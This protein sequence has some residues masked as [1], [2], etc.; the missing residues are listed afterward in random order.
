MARRHVGALVS[1][2]LLLHAPCMADIVTFTGA[3]SDD[4]HTSSNWDKGIPTTTDRVIIPANLHAVIRLDDVTV[5]TVE[6][7]AEASLTV[8]PGLTLELRNGIKNIGG[9]GG[10]SRSCR[11]GDNSRIDGALVLGVS[12][13]EG[14]T[15]RIAS[16]NHLFAGDGMIIG[17]GQF[18]NAVIL[19]DSG[20]TL[21]NE[22]AEVDNG[23]RGAMTITGDGHLHNKGRVDAV[24]TLEIET[25]ISDAEGAIWTVGCKSFMVFHVGSVALEGD[26]SDR[27]AG[28][29]RPGPGMFTFH[30]PVSTCGEYRRACGGITITGQ[31]TYFEY[32]D[33]VDLSNAACSNPGSGGPGG[34]EDP[35]IVTSSV[36]SASCGEP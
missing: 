34:C 27:P 31:G 23:I 26:F 3:T 11:A 6:I 19:I 1:A 15:L 20:R 16:C 18:E 7:E 21:T 32:A 2:S 30:E 25:T 14:A 22:L 28:Q 12:E 13:T 17:M 9:G 29:I 4:W 33:F 24:D 8:E 10:P 36:N 35:W 5:D